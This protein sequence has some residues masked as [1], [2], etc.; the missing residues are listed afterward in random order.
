MS[1]FIANH[2]DEF[3]N[4]LEGIKAI[5]RA[6]DLYLTTELTSSNHPAN[7][8]KVAKA[9]YGLAKKNQRFLTNKDIKILATIIKSVESKGQ[10]YA[11]EKENAF[12]AIIQKIKS[13]NTLNTPQSIPE[14]PSKEA[15][16]KQ[17]KA[18][19]V[20]VTDQ[21]S[22]LP[23]V[24]GEVIEKTKSI[25]K[26]L[27]MEDLP[28]EIFELILSNLGSE[29]YKSFSEV[30][31]RWHKTILE[32]AKK[33]E[34]LLFKNFIQFIIDYYKIQKKTVNENCLWQKYRTWVFLN[35]VFDQKA[36]AYLDSLQNSLNFSASS[37][38]IKLKSL[39]Y[40]E[41]IKFLIAMKGSWGQGWNKLFLENLKEQTKAL[42]LPWLFED[43]FSPDI[44][45]QNHL[46]GSIEKLISESLFD[47]VTEIA[48]LLDE[49]PNFLEGVTLKLIEHDQCEQAFKVANKIHEDSQFIFLKICAA[50]VRK[51]HWDKAMELSKKFKKIGCR[52]IRG[53]SPEDQKNIALLQTTFHKFSVELAK[54][55]QVEKGLD[56]KNI[57]PDTLFKNEVLTTICDMFAQAGQL[58]Q[59]LEIAYTIAHE[60]SQSLA[61]ENISLL[62][63]KAGHLE[64]ALEIA[65]TIPNKGSKSSTLENVSLLFA[66]AG[67]LEKALEIGNA[68]PSEAL[69]QKCFTL[70]YISEMF[71][72]AGHLEKALEIA[73]TIPDEVSKNSAVRKISQIFAEAD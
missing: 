25:S 23:T 42:E 48:E 50:L 45:S 21:G 67:H 73:H 37:T 18:I 60:D 38:L 24:Q 30:N 44:N 43:I 31:W 26:F 46:T 2:R 58:E 71:A 35:S 59:A 7:P 47:K 13:L 1:I 20:S 9:V 64:K 27:E 6:D 61:L 22:P 41:K 70:T 12:I 29:N 11:E 51:G 14:L 8:L 33:K 54:S 19:Q 53:C 69:S 5:S 72:K 68:I 57:I 66:Q 55:R 10:K 4:Y 28:Q 62:F 39:I 3:R 56:F 34:A 65:H 36:L 15:V 17:E 32:I 49:N 40:C 52:E 16:D 63:A